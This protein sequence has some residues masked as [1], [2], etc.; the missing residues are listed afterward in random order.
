M[1]DILA[2]SFMTATRVN[3]PETPKAATPKPI[4]KPRWAAPAYW[5]QR[6]ELSADQDRQ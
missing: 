3:A 6:P 5:R 1:L 2:R 4:A